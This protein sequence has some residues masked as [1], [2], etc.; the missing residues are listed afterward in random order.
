LTY[1]NFLSLRGLYRSYDLFEP[2]AKFNFER[3]IA[4]M[5][6]QNA[7]KANYITAQAKGKQGKEVHN[8]PSQA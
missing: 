8:Q 3:T 5:A 7:L 4:E 1:A 6:Y 2:Y